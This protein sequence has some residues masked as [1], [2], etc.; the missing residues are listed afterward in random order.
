MNDQTT[1]VEISRSALQHNLSGLRRLFDSGHASTL[2]PV[3]KANAYGHGLCAIA[4]ACIECGCDVFCINEVE[5]GKILRAHGVTARLYVVGPTF[6]DEAPAIIAAD[7]EV[8][9]FSEAQVR[10]LAEAAGA[11]GATVGVHVKIETGTHRQGLPPVQAKALIQCISDTPGVVLAGVTTHLADVEDETEHTFARTQ[12]ERFERATA[13]VPAEV[14]RHCASSAAHI[15]FPSARWDMVRVGIATYGLWPS[16]ETRIS[17]D[18]VHKGALSL[19]PVLSWRTRLIQ[20]T[21]VKKGNYVGY[22]RAHRVSSD[23]RVGLLPVGYFD[24]FDRSASGK[25]Q[26]LVQGHRAPI[27]GRI[28]MNMTMVDVTDI[29]GAAVGDV[30][31]L[32]GQDGD[33]YIGATELAEWSDTI[34]Y[35]IVSRIHARFP[36]IVLP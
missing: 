30:V 1:W 5:E 28:C 13:D 3:I 9:V 22:G 12:L 24:G 8:V 17:A 29:E 26:V 25:G 18:I 21:E 31:T 15:L 23:R 20:L 16:R 10:A 32:I 35:E 11:A 19:A 14:W 36:R 7:L 6:P 27:L 34:N 2:A 4:D 33:E